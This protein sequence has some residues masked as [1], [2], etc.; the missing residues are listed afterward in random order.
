[1]RRMFEESNVTLTSIYRI[2]GLCL[3]VGLG[4]HCQCC[5]DRGFLRIVREE[6]LVRCA[7]LGFCRG[8]PGI[9]SCCEGESSSGMC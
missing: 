6:A 5:P 1:M 7:G 4:F 9:P 3:F 8:T 2:R